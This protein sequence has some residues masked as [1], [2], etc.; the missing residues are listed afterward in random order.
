M[1]PPGEYAGAPLRPRRERC[2]EPECR[3]GGECWRCDAE[4]SQAL[5]FPPPAYGC[6]PGSKDE[7]LPAHVLVL[8]SHLPLTYLSTAC[9]VAGQLDRV[10]N[11]LSFRGLPLTDHDSAAVQL[12]VWSRTMHVR[13]RL[14]NKFTGVA[15]TCGCH[16]RS[17][18]SD[19]EAVF[20]DEAPPKGW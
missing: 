16:P 4:E 10:A 20:L 15:C 13:C 5:P 18:E 7:Q 19:G 9:E 11:G 12:D 14:T 6:T 8:L 1:N 17:P 3:A 2:P